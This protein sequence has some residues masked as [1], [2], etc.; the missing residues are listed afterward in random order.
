MKQGPVLIVDEETPKTSLENLLD[1]FSQGFGLKTYH[2][3]PINV[4]SMGGFRFGRKVSLD[5][6]LKV[7]DTI[8]PVFIPLDS[9]IAMLPGG[10]ARISENDSNIG[11]AIRDDLN[12]ILSTC[13][14]SALLTTH[15]KKAVADFAIEELR[16]AGMQNLVRGHGSIVGQGCDTGF[17]IK[18]LSEHPRPTRFAVI[19]KARRHAIPISAKVV[20]VELEEGSL[21]ARFR[22]VERD[23][24]RG[25]SAI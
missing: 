23:T 10:R 12:A 5:K 6:L 18:K 8:K 20:Y 9:L 13:P 19:T 3:L 16:Y 1:R 24:A 4:A 7:V 2:D 25:Y 14:C 11:E 22:Q 17:V 21:W 15:T